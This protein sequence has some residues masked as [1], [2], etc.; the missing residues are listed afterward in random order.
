MYVYS[1]TKTEAEKPN[2]HDDNGERKPNKYTKKL[3]KTEWQAYANTIAKQ[4]TNY[5]KS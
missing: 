1:S 2:R 4:T 5:Y 3:S